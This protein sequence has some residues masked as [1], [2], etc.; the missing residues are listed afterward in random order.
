MNTSI[1]FKREICVMCQ[2]NTAEARNFSSEYKKKYYTI[3]RIK[4]VFFSKKKMWNT[5]SVLSSV[6]YC[7]EFRIL[8]KNLTSRLITAVMFFI[9][10]LYYYF[11]PG[12]LSF[13]LHCGINNFYN[14]INGFMAVFPKVAILT[15]FCDLFPSAADVYL[16]KQTYLQIGRFNA[17]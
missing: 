13:F 3:F 6:L 9:F 11:F 10:F 17:N 4:D 8:T 7:S 5:Y 14:Y 16:R 1:I 2:V 15:L 12:F